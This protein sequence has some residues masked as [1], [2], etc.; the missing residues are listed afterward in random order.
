M[1]RG[2][3][4]KAVDEPRGPSRACATSRARLDAPPQRG[5]GQASDCGRAAATA[6]AFGPE[7]PM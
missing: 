5:Y 3:R 7:R 4:A 1:G 6:A 2:V